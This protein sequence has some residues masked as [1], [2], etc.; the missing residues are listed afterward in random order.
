MQVPQVTKLAI[1]IFTHKV[2]LEVQL[3][4]GFFPHQGFT[5]LCMTL[6]LQWWGQVQQAKYLLTLV[7]SRSFHLEPPK[8]VFNTLCKTKEVHRINILVSEKQYPK[9][10]FF[11][12]RLLMGLAVKSF[13]SNLCEEQLS[14]NYMI[15]LVVGFILLQL[16]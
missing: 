12:R 3:V 2:F 8:T 13:A 1:F 10:L 15:L 6:I 5:F 9:D 7:S 4:I 14:C 11:L 16:I